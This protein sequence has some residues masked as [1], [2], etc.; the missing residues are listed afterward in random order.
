MCVSVLSC[1]KYDCK[2]ENIYAKR[3][4][5]STS[6]PPTRPS[7]PVA[8]HAFLFYDAA[9]CSE[10]E[11]HLTRQS[12]ELGGPP[13]AGSSDPMIPPISYGP[14]MLNR[15]ML[16]SLLFSQGFFFSVKV[17]IL[18][19]AGYSGGASQTKFYKS[20]KKIVSIS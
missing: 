14:H 16:H 17:F 18:Y 11:K 13:S 4:P 12:A 19:P 6:Q 2:C 1:L 15:K 5:T 20:S 3:A 7:V 10:N 9:T 8:L